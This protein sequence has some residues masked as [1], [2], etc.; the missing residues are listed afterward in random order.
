[1]NLKINNVKLCNNGLC[2][3]PFYVVNFMEYF[4]N[5]TKE[6]M[7][8]IVFPDYDGKTD[9]YKFKSNPKVAI[10]NT[11][12]GE[13]SEPCDYYADDLISAINENLGVELLKE[14][15]QCQ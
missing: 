5:N 12:V 6:N 1:M 15:T 7:T 3:Q 10:F 9:S 11:T 14:L 8:A 13:N 2:G 4:D